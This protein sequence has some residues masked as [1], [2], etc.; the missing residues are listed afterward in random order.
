MAVQ[1]PGTTAGLAGRTSSRLSAWGASLALAVAF[2]GQ[3]PLSAAALW[4]RSGRFPWPDFLRIALQCSAQALFIIITVNILVGA[5]LAFVGAVQLVKFGAGIYVADLVGVSVVREMAAMMTAVVMAGRSGASFAAELATMQSNEEVDALAVLG[6][7]T[8]AY[9]VVPRVLALTLTLPLLYVFACAAGLLG[10][11]MVAT[12]MMDLTASA[13][14]DR[15]ALILVP[16][17]F[18][19][20]GMKAVSFGFLI[21]LTGCW[22]G[23]HAKRTAA[24]VGDAAT[25][26]V[27]TSI[28]WVI[29]LDAVFALCANAIHV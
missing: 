7:D 24:G 9:L 16:P 11:L 29:V 13:Y 14:I 20:G 5:I 17:N 25:R 1:A 22:Y 18:V 12:E 21:G 27:V 2:L 28:V 19:L 10:G 6:L 4:T 26:T 23:L 3:I 8:E 15:T